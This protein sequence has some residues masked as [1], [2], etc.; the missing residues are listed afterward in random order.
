MNQF[1][2]GVNAGNAADFKTLSLVAQTSSGSS[3]STLA[4]P[5]GVQAG[6]LIFVTDMAYRT[7]TH[8]TL[9][10]PS[11]FTTLASIQHTPGGGFISIVISC[12]VAVGTESGVSLQMMTREDGDKAIFVLRPNIAIESFVRDPSP[13][14][15]EASS[16][17]TFPNRTISAAALVDNP[18]VAFSYWSNVSSG[19]ANNTRCDLDPEESGSVFY[20]T[21]TN[22]CLM[23]KTF[24]SSDVPVDVDVLNA[25]WA[26]AKYNSR[27][28]LKLGF[29]G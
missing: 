16:S 17:T 15:L 14:A 1:P 4:V 20:G 23:W 22:S 3:G 7:N 10:T 9:A 21:S 2:F 29:G 18:R 13:W 28:I 12:K 6:D 24:A 8:P 27:G 25:S 5:T 26:G 11:G 19:G